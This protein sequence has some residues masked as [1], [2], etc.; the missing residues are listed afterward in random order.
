MFFKN[1]NKKEGDSFRHKRKQKKEKASKKPAFSQKRS[2]FL[3][4]DVENL[5]FSPFRSNFCLLF[6]FP[7]LDV[8]KY[9]SRS[10]TK[11]S[12]LNLTSPFARNIKIELKELGFQVKTEFF[13]LYSYVS[14]KGLV[15][16]RTEF[17]VL[18]REAYLCTS[19]EKNGKS[20]QKFNPN[21]ENRRFSTLNSM[22][23]NSP[24]PPQAVPRAS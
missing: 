5:R 1:E 24:H 11:N 6:P 8:R 23:T 13:D 21:G 7:S 15:R 12:A 3:G 9:A 18:E 10:E 20:K 16:F 22:K 4:I 14:C 2:K 17:F 19:S